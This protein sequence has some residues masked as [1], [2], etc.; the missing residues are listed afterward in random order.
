MGRGSAEKVEADVSDYEELRTQLT[1]AFVTDEVGT[2]MR[3]EWITTDQMEQIR[4]D[5]EREVEVAW[6]LIE[7]ELRKRDDNCAQ[8]AD[9]VGKLRSI[10]YDWQAAELRAIHAE[11]RLAEVQRLLNQARMFMDWAQKWFPPPAQFAAMDRRLL[12]DF[13]AFLNAPLQPPSSDSGPLFDGQSATP[14]SEGDE[15]RLPSKDP[16]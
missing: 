1:E 4:E 7:A 5:S 3:P 9:E 12:N 16:A 15:G 14:P 2:F 10:S 8:A 11:Q 13:R 6:P